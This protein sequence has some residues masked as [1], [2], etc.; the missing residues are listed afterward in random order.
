MDEERI[1]AMVE[2]SSLED[3]S[4][5]ATDPT[6]EQV[7]E[8]G[9]DQLRTPVTILFSD[10]KGS[11]SYFERKGDLEGLAMLERHNDL[12]LPCVEGNNGRL[13]KTIG[14]ALMTEFRDP[15]D[16]LRAAVE[17][18]NALFEDG[19]DRPESD[20]I[21]I[22]IGV[23]TGLGLIRGND[24][25]GDVVNAAAKVQYKAL[26]DQILITDSLVPAA[27][28]AGYQV[29]RLGRTKLA[30]KEEP[31]DVFTMAWSAA[32]TQRLID[33]LQSRFEDQVRDL[34]QARMTSEEDF[35]SARSEW[36][37]ER[38][39]L[40]AEVAR[41]E[42]GIRDALSTARAQIT[43]EFRKELRFELEKSEKARVQAERDLESA[44]ERFEAE[45]VGYRAQIETLEKRV[46]EALDRVNNPARMAAE[47]QR[48]V[49]ERLERARR[50][51]E[52]QW[53]TERERMTREIAQLQKAG[54]HDPLAEA[55]RQVQER[56]RARQASA[57]EAGSP[58]G[59]AE[60]IRIERDALKTR[61][62]QLETEAKDLEET[63]RRELSRDLR[64]RFDERSEQAARVQGQLEHEV[65]TLR[66]EL[67]AQKESFATR[68]SE[69][70][71]SIPRA[72]DAA[73]AQA[74]AELEAEFQEKVD[75]AERARAALERRLRDDSEEWD[76]ERSKLMGRLDDMEMRL[77]EA[78]DMA[79]RRSDEPGIEEL[80]RLRHQLEEEYR[81]RH[82]AW[83]AEKRDL[84]DRIRELEEGSGQS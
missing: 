69:L 21:H 40:H 57:G 43:E 81:D 73:R 65:E 68:I 80:N 34:K 76:F 52:A 42:D 11:T 18:Q 26:P 22:R 84:L 30:G 4:G 24:V 41:L 55:R 36:R 25:F 31:I 61:V 15:V 27:Q 47:V 29:G 13:V 39:E 83:D 28:T 62:G 46:V 6:L 8:S 35:D 59:G 44:H 82:E 63:V 20:Q 45:R 60:E 71:A 17:M 58:S 33:D 78:R 77:E 74:I 37:R 16:A 1:E 2:G 51:L 5:S 54:G 66:S 7:A 12:L 19:R 10:I 38:R 32:S 75:E 23:H 79:F 53:A 56:L 48:Q 72:Q 49:E 9:D 3:T 50:Q 64:R 14:D 70:E 67:A